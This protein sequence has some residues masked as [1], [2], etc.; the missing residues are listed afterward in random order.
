MLQSA[1]RSSAR[2]ILSSSATNKRWAALFAL[3]VL[4]GA[5]GCD[6]VV[7]P[8][9]SEAP[10]EP[11]VMAVLAPADSTQHLLLSS[12]LPVEQAG[13][14]LYL[15]DATVRVGGVRYRNVPTDSLTYCARVVSGRK[16]SCAT[17]LVRVPESLSQSNYL[18]RTLNVEAGRRYELEVVHAETRITGSTRVPDTFS[19][20]AA[21]PRRIAW[22]PSAGAARY[23][24]QLV[25]LR[26]SMPVHRAYGPTADTSIVLGEHFEPRSVGVP[27]DSERSGSE[28]YL[29][30]VEAYDAHMAR[31]VQLGREL[32]DP[33]RLRASVQGGLGLFGAVTTVADTLM[34]GE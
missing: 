4:L 23:R 21:G 29:V 6:H 32:V 24:A 12:A 13:G 34:L 18:S 5:A 31:Y 9:S 27:S 3:T 1:L 19:V 33:R 26:D 2:A 17:E 28:A 11:F 30:W 25:R 16:D 10:D 7:D 20:E 8:T 22:T 15:Q 14:F